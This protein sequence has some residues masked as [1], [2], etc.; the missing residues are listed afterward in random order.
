MKSKVVVVSLLVILFTGLV[1]ATE[2]GVPLVGKIIGDISI[3]N[4]IDFGTI[5]IGQKPEKM[6]VIQ[7]NNQS[8]GLQLNLTIINESK[9][10]C[11][12]NVVEPNSVIHMLEKEKKLSL[13]VSTIGNYTIEAVCTEIGYESSLILVEYDKNLT[14]VHRV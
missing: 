13:D 7:I 12:Y 14:A 10:H 11:K 8:T 4:N 2:V 6:M 1:V 3:P 9:S 5:R